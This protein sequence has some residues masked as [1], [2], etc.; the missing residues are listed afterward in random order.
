[1]ICHTNGIITDFG[2]HG[3]FLGQYESFYFFFKLMTVFYKNKFIILK[4][5]VIRKYIKKVTNHPKSWK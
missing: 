5:Q 4:V 1:M 2:D 3:A